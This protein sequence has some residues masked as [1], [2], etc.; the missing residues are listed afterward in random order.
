M[1][2]LTKIAL[3][4]GKTA[5][6]GTI[7]QF[8]SLTEEFRL[9]LHLF[10]TQDLSPLKKFPCEIVLYEEN[11]Q[12]PG[13]LTGLEERLSDASMIIAFES[14]ALSSFQACRAADRLRIAF[15]I[16]NSEW[17]Q[18]LYE[19]APNIRAIQFDILRRAH[20]FICNDNFSGQ[21]LTNL[22]V[23]PEKV[24]VIPY[25]VDR[26]QFH[27]SLPARDRFRKYIGLD[28][29]DKV[30]LFQGALS[31]H[32]G[33]DIA[34]ETVALLRQYKTD[35]RQQIK[36]VIA[37]QGY[38]GHR[39][40][41]LCVEKGLA[42]HALFLE[43]DLE[44]FSADLYNAVDYALY[45]RQQQSSEYDH[46]PYYLLEQ[47][48]CGVVPVVVKD[49][50]AAAV[51]QGA[52]IEVASS[53]PLAF[54]LALGVAMAT[55]S[56]TLGSMDSSYYLHE[57]D[58]FRSALSALICKKM[59]SVTRGESQSSRW[60]ADF[61]AVESLIKDGHLDDA[62]IAIE[63][64]LLT[65]VGGGE[66]RSETLRLCG[67]IKLQL[68]QYP[69]AMEAYHQSLQQHPANSGSFRGLGNLAMLGHSNEEAVVFFRKSLAL[70]ARDGK[71]MLGLG[72]IY[73]RVGLLDHALFWL[74]KALHAEVEPRTAL[75]ALTQVCSEFPRPQIAI[76]CLREVIETMGEHKAL[77]VC[78]GKL[79]LK[80]GMV[81]EG[82][83]LLGMAL[84]KDAA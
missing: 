58:Q 82:Q 4:V 38:D 34:I 68:G 1:S 74:E 79:Y 19:Q 61:C 77:L 32:S 44:R 15:G 70:D 78:L 60:M 29:Q 80:I 30:V 40:K 41:L 27:P 43:Q 76:K 31:E 22:G 48:A 53:S 28:P 75:A 67:D 6:I 37:G 49:S 5:Q 81:A 54:A 14:T 35:K 51:A 46:P 59:L 56:E 36:L 66:A 2:V 13:Y 63:R 64:M 33:A 47:V 50:V 55:A 84:A 45:H 16:F 62:N 3:V 83:E 25:E 73:K 39:L 11:P 26:K 12:M 7:K 23:S 10:H 65:D 21:F 52:G 20:F 18:H 72:L 42:N 17:Q 8:M 57:N 9:V 24:T 69:D 71:V